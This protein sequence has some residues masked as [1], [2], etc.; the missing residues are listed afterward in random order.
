MPRPRA[1]HP[2]RGPWA[3]GR[4]GST[5]TFSFC[6]LA[7]VCSENTLLDGHFFALHGG[8]GFVMGH[9]D[10]ADR[11][12]L[13]AYIRDHI[14]K[15]YV[16]NVRIN[17]PDFPA[18]STSMYVP[19]HVPSIVHGMASTLQ[20]HTSFLPVAVP[21]GMM[22]GIQPM[23]K[24]WCVGRTQQK[25]QEVAIKNYTARVPEGFHNTGVMCNCLTIHNASEF[26]LPT[27]TLCNALSP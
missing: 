16:D 2:P 10:D 13:D 20:L 11:T 4:H 8:I 1:K 18:G 24:E 12:V 25:C 21:P 27:S 7:L 19:W 22:C 23:A 3:V 5:S 26:R 9:V 14:D 15:F 17:H 6:I